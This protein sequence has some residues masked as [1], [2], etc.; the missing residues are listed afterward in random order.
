MTGF[1]TALARALGDDARESPPRTAPDGAAVTAGGLAA[2]AGDESTRRPPV[3]ITLPAGVAAPKDE[4]AGNGG[5]GR[6]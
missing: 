2:D 5:S 3:Q 6:R 4:D 1:A